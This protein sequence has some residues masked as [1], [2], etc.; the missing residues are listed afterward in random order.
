MS[1]R[2]IVVPVILVIP[3]AGAV[4]AAALRQK[5]H[6]TDDSEVSQKEY[7]IIHVQSGVVRVGIESPAVIEPYRQWIFR[8]YTTA[9]LSFVAQ[10]GVDVEE[11]SG[12]DS[13]RCL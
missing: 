4:T 7:S 2:K 5:A 9:Q 3:I 8:A 6:V 10:Q 12:A 1:K 13:F 11:V